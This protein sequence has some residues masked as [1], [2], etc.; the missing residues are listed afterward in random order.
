MSLILLAII[1]NWWLWC[2]LRF[3]F[4]SYKNL[5]H[6]HCSVLCILAIDGEYTNY[7]Q[8]F[9]WIWFLAVSSYKRISMMKW[10]QI[11]LHN[12]PWQDQ[13]KDWNHRDCWT[14]DLL[15]IFGPGNDPD[16]FAFNRGQVSVWEFFIC[17]AVKPVMWWWLLWNWM[18]TCKEIYKFFL[19]K[20][21]G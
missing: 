6:F 16:R 7:L 18:S 9:M 2:W 12:V 11:W 14:R 20:F 13:I 4:F 3:D 10:V 21:I 5:Y 15:F 1:W 17:L 8:I 19:A